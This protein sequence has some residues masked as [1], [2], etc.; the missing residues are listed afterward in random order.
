MNHGYCKNCWWWKGESVV[1]QVSKEFKNIW[2]S[3]NNKKYPTVKG[4]C[5]MQSKNIGIPG[6][7]FLKETTESEYCPDYVNR[8]KEEKE[9]GTLENWID[10]QR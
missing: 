9:N 4:V 2:E 1:P 3:L 5:Y 7:E 8:K 6:A 10:S